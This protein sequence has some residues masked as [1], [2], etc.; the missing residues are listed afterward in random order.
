MA[1][2]INL[3]RSSLTWSVGA[4][5]CVYGANGAF[6]SFST[7]L[8]SWSIE[9]GL[10]DERRR[11]KLVIIFKLGL[12]HHLFFFFF[13]LS[14]Y[15]SFSLSWI[16][17]PFTVQ[18]GESELE[19][20]EEEWNGPLGRFILLRQSYVHALL[21]IT[22]LAAHCSTFCVRALASYSCCAFA[23]NQ[24]FSFLRPRLKN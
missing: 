20:K 15:L 8:S 19:E 6:S 16:Y 1:Q 21:L 24:N 18:V 22:A 11:T 13:S 4:S 9:K 23:Y 5:F 2:T 14:L 17:T 3:N 7:L 12:I 10:N